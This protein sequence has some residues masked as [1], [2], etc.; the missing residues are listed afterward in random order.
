[1]PGSVHVGANLVFALAT[2][3]KAV[4]RR[5][6][7]EHKVRPYILDDEFFMKLFAGYIF[8]QHNFIL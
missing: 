1:M 6:K 4:G 7:G 2:I 3:C 5:Y 8:N